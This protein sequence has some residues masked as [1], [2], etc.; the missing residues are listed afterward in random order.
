[1]RERKELRKPCQKAPQSRDRE[2]RAGEEPGQDRDRGHP[3]DV[4]LL[5]RNTAR[6]DLGHPVH[7]R[8]EEHSRC[9]EPVAV[10]GCAVEGGRI[11]EIDL[12]AN[13]AKLAHLASGAD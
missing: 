6:Q 4:L 12:V 11:V 7:A 10:V 1:V 13:R 3:G 5:P 2:E 9:D 8:G